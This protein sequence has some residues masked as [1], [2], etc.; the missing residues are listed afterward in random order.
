M[1]V[2]NRFFLEAL[3]MNKDAV[4]VIISITLAAHAA[5]AMLVQGVEVMINDPLC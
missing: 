3:Y 2:G 5:R 4:V 1:V